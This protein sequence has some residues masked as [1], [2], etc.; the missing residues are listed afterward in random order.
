MVLLSLSSKALTG[1][2]TISGTVETF[3]KKSTTKPILYSSAWL[4][5][6]YKFPFFYCWEVVAL[7]IS[8]RKQKTEKNK[9]IKDELRVFCDYISCYPLSKFYLGSLMLSKRSDKNSIVTSTFFD[10]NTAILPTKLSGL[11]YFST[12]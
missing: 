6:L 3:Q 2:P 7:M 8:V 12:M 11:T 4:A 1:S 9:V 5:V 10:L